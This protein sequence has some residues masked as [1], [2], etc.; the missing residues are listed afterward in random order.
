VRQLKPERYWEFLKWLYEHT[1]EPPLRH[2]GRSVLTAEEV[3]LLV[4]EQQEEK[5]SG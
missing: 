3:D 4:A 5:K 2:E 1:L